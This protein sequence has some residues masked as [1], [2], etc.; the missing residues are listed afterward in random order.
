MLPRSKLW[1]LTRIIFWLLS[2]GR[3][4]DGSVNDDQGRENAML[5]NSD[6]NE[7]LQ[8][9]TSSQETLKR[10][11]SDLEDEG[12]GGTTFEDFMDEDD[13]E[14]H[15]HHRDVFKLDFLDLLTLRS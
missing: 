5:I 4:S 15:I 9:T 8:K 10:S 14:D 7:P 1:D 12:G 6:M 13:E 2:V 3:I 11:A